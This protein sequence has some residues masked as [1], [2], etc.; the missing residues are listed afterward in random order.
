MYFDKDL[1]QKLDVVFLNGML[2]LIIM[3]YK[4]WLKVIIRLNRSFI[5][6]FPFQNW[7]IKLS[8][9]LIKCNSIKTRKLDIISGGKWANVVNSWSLSEEK[10][11]FSSLKSLIISM[12]LYLIMIIGIMN[13]NWCPEEQSL[14]IYLLRN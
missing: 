9:D 10:T 7:I 6:L 12:Y 2:V 13:E 8:K 11:F 5:N 3:V 14:N 4:N 1:K